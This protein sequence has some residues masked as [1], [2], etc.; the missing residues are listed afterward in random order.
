VVVAT[1][2]G[3]QQQ[4]LVSNEARKIWVLDDTEPECEDPSWDGSVV[5]NAGSLYLPVSV[6]GGLVEAELYNTKNLL[7]QG[8]FDAA[9]NDITADFTVSGVDGDVTYTYAGA[10]PAP[11][12]VHLKVAAA[13]PGSSSFFLR[14][15][16]DCTT[17][18]IDPVLNLTVSDR[19][20]LNGNYP[21]P[22]SG[23]TTISFDVVR[24]GNVT[25]AVYDVLGQLIKTL[26]ATDLQSGRHDVIWDGTAS[27]GATVASGL[28]L[29]RITSGE[30]SQTRHM[31]LI[32]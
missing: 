1:A 23:S 20:A 28:Y 2:I 26:A 9:F 22:F 27:S 21:N 31:T 32:R 6:P 5:E 12:F 24:E 3:S 17:I 10:G 7:S 18:D 15:Q 30:Q 4:S 19:F 25:V 29:Y 8:V 13:G 14:V 11:E 16:N